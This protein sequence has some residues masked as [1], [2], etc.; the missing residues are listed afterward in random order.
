M[1]DNDRH[2]FLTQNG[3]WANQRQGS[4]R[5]ASLHRTQREA[6][7]SARE[8]LR[9]S[10]GGDLVTHGLDG[11]IRSKDTIGRPDP[12]PPRDREH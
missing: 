7:D 1:A 11:R 6:E 9:N 2:V 4:D 10:G 3:M 8:M 5:P 12:L